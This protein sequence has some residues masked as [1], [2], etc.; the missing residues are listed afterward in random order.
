MLLRH[1]IKRYRHQKICIVG[2]GLGGLSIASQLASKDHTLVI[3]DTHEPGDGGASAVAAG[4]LHPLTPK[5]N[6]I[7]KGEEGLEST[8]QLITRVEKYSQQKIQHKE[9]EII[10]PLHEDFQYERYRKSV[11][12]HSKVCDLM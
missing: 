5:G 12:K 7:W 3:Y 10:R 2:G 9:K 8:E 1:V 11:E 4:L 6:I